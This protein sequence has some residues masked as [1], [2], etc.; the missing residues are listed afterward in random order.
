MNTLRAYIC[1]ALCNIT[2]PNTRGLS[3]YFLSVSGVQRMHF[4]LCNFNH[5]AWA[6]KLISLSNLSRE[7]G[8]LFD[9]IRE[10][11]SQT[12]ELWDSRHNRELQAEAAEL[13]RMGRELNSRIRRLAGEISDWTG[14]PTADQLSEEEYFRSMVQILQ[15]RL[16]TLRDRIP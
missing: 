14:S 3:Q 2:I 12:E 8:P 11:V 16:S 15:E 5:H 13:E 9:G 6:E 4:K 10:M 7:S 1:T